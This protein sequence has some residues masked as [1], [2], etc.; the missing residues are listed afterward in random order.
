MDTHLTEPLLVEPPDL[1]IAGSPALLFQP[2]V[3]LATGQLL[4]FEAL[5]RWVVP[6][7]EMVLPNAFIPWAEARGRMG[8]L[9]A[10]VLSEACAQAMRWP[11]RI[12]IAVNC[13]IFQVHAGEATEAVMVALE[14]SGM[15]PDRLMLEVPAL[16]AA[17]DLTT[18]VTDIT[19]LGVQLSMD[20]VASD[21]PLLASLA[22]FAAKTIKIDGSLVSRL[23]RPGEESSRSTVVSIIDLSRSLGIC[24]VA[25]C[26]ETANQATILRVLGAD[27][28]QGYLFSHPV[29]AE[30]AA[31]MANA[32]PPTTF[33]WND[34]DP[35]NSSELSPPPS[36]L[37][38]YQTSAA[39]S[40][41]PLAQGASVQGASGGETN[42]PD[43]AHEAPESADLLDD[44]IQELAAMHDKV[45]TS[46]LAL[47]DLE[48]SLSTLLARRSD[49]SAN[50]RIPKDQ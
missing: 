23:D 2:V 39:S 40:F 4:G 45:K 6:G 48:S 26:V 21:R 22:N 9:N 17:A 37:Q 19:Q 18:G 16:G 30:R 28:A 38:M 36:P 47:A 46:L 41:E 44:D 24:T 12:Q 13:T 33:T 7:R 3:D 34:T 5:L 20:D 43:Q 11:S 14:R 1:G 31:A 32:K 15:N 25:E 42:P 49:A 10:W 50:L 29:A 27:V 35:I 8:D